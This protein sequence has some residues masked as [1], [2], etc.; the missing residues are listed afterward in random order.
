MY[1]ALQYLKDN[2][3]IK[4]WLEIIEKIVGIPMGTNCASIVA[5][6]FWFCYEELCVVYL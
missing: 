3:F 6:L 4:F 1:D 2:I 5:D